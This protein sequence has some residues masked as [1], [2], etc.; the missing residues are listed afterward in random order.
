MA[1]ACEGSRT[2]DGGDSRLHPQNYCRRRRSE[3]PAAE[4]GRASDAAAVASAAAAA[5]PP[6]P[7]VPPMPAPPNRRWQREQD[8]IEAMLAQAGAMSSARLPEPEES[9]PADILDLT[10]QMTAVPSPEAQGF[11]TI[12]GRPTS[13][14][15]PPPSAANLT[16]WPATAS[17]DRTLISPSTSA[18]VDFGVQHARPDRAGAE[19]PHARGPGAGNAASDAQDLA[20]RQ[21]AGH[22]GAPGARR[23]RA[24]LARAILIFLTGV[25]RLTAAYA[26]SPLREL[27]REPQ[28][29]RQER[30]RGHDEQRHCAVAV[31]DEGAG[32]PRP[33]IWP[34]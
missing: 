13:R 28:G 6:P 22:G 9:L 19:R 14:P 5:S 4:S 33:S 20:R 30:D 16:A 15:K 31:E 27:A 32:T 26:S 10:E 29:Q 23:D 12:D 24:R 11:R 8:D 25:A 2:L 17:N 34:R 7:P 21:S 18:A 3:G 1:Q